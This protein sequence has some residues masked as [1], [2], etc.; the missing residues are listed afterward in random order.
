M[1][2]YSLEEA[3]DI[4]MSAAPYSQST[5]GAMMRNFGAAAQLM[6]AHLRATGARAADAGDAGAAA[7][8]QAERHAA[9]FEQVANNSSEAAS[10]L[11]TLAAKGNAHQ[12]TAQEVYAGYQQALANDSGPNPSGFADKAVITQS[13][14]GSNT[15][16]AAVD[17]W[18]AAYAGFTMPKP[19]PVPS[20]GG[21]HGGGSGTAPTGSHYGGG[22]SGSAP[23]S[24]GGSEPLLV[25]GA[26]PTGG[27]PVIDRGPG[28]PGSVQVGT[29]GGDFAGWFKDPRTGYYVDPTTGREFDPVTNRWVDP[30][31]GL[32]FGDVTK[33]AT[34]LQG[35]AGA[36]TS[37]GLLADTTA[38]AGGVA[39]L[40][41]TGEGGFAP[42]FS[43]AGNTAA[44]AGG[45][46]GM[47]PPS[48][49]TGSAASSSLWQQAGR[50]LAVKQQVAETMLAREQAVRAGRAYL[51][52]AQAGLGSA[53]GG[54]RARGRPGYLTAEE[55]EAGLF[56]SRTPR[57]AYL[58]PAQ[59]GTGKD[60]EKANAERRPAWLAEDDVFTPDPAPTG[61]LGD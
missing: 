42:L 57:R 53:A 55:D 49:V 17:D 36:S 50:S 43:G 37:G 6:A 29:D 44:V 52:P 31:T 47:L 56:S 41:G 26:I 48:L 54:G 22:T 33:Y 27:N 32:P 16:S 45:Y 38:T 12:A 4:L 23:R 28:V 35:L 5:G 13:A 11:D 20:S 9:W 46:G 21:A 61:I 10:K 15:L 7:Q 40:S 24:T 19:P 58:P 60:S 2:T 51:P 8:T 59:A 39:G 18:G 30:V 14:Q 1:A 25:A 34:G 3:H